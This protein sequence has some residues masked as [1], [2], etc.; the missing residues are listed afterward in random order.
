MGQPFDTKRRFKRCMQFI[1]ILFVSFFILVSCGIPSHFY[2]YEGTSG[3][4]SSYYN[5]TEGDES[6]TIYRDTYDMEF[7]IDIDYTNSSVSS[8]VGPSLVY[9]Y[10]IVPM[11]FAD[12]KIESITDK[13]QI[14]FKKNYIKNNT[15]R[16]ISSSA[17][18]VMEIVYDDNT[19]TMNKFQIFNADTNSVINKQSPS[20]YA[21][22]LGSTVA[23]DAT[24]NSSFGFQYK[25]I[26]GSDNYF[27]LLL[28]Q[29]NDDHFV[30]TGSSK[31]DE[32]DLRMY[33][34]N[35]FFKSW[36]GEAS[37]YSNLN[38]GESYKIIVYSALNVSEGLG[39]TNIFWSSLQEVGI[40]S[41]DEPLI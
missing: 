39:F 12:G 6:S 13:F 33:N 34:G 2:M 11:D 23:F 20:M 41:S 28:D 4:S 30:A 37:G 15:G 32:I 36:D 16:Q 38:T 26:V 1:L 8:V 19:Y 27:K 22:E 3:T 24:Y 7:R 40:I 9:L 29:T 18:D 31:S 14:N 25:E 17:D 10:T 35:K 5:F 21:L